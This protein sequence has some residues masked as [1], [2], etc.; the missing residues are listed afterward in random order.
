MKKDVIKIDESI[1]KNLYIISN[2]K[3]GTLTIIDGLCNTIIKEIEV[4]KRPYNLALKDNNTVAV[5]CDISNT[6]SFVNCING[7]IKQSCIPND[8]NLQIDRINKKIFISN[9]SEVIIYDIKLEKLLGRIS[10][11]LAVIDLK[12]NKDGSMLYILDTLM[13]E[14][15]IYSTDSYKL[16]YS[17]ANLG[18]NPNYFIIS[19]DDKIAYISIGSNIL[20]IDIYSKKIIEL[21]LPKESLISGMVL[22]DHTL[23]ASNLGLNRIELINIHTNI[24]YDFI[25]T[26]TP[27]PTRLFITDD[28][29][30]LLVT[31][32]NHESH[33]TM[34]IIDLNSNTLIG[35]ILMSKFNSQPYDVIS[36]SLP[37]T[38]VLP[39]AITD[40]QQGDQGITI[41]AKKIFAS[42]NENIDFPII[43]INLPKDTNSQKDINS[44]YIFENII[45]KPGII[46]GDSEIRSRLS[47]TSG[48]SSI[49]FIVRVN[50]IIEYIQN[51]KNNIM[52]GYF[53]KPI[54]IFFDIPK[55]HEINELELNIK[56]TTKLT[57]TPKILLNVI[58][59]GVTTRID[60][61]IIGED[62]IYLNN[63]EET[64]DN[65]EEH[66][67]AFTGSI[68]RIFP[69]GAAFPF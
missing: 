16:I 10:G 35:S 51:N 39:V 11:F 5:A 18:V 30:K 49:K 65:L 54:E 25:L 8:G 22:K 7:E 66:Y 32:R 62:E 4:G 37:Y 17:L 15:R 50:Y 46:V 57:D 64:S 24:A 61:K 60:I 56:T 6:I 63:T 59:F 27:E 29:T 26:S 45:F 9:T 47:T 28:N 67:E 38:Y 13:K 36:L 40:L 44:T 21:I 19:E 48:F 58:G 1:K 43:N 41:I 53:E 69:G 20:K 68:D 33:G 14:L 3:N 52:N 2:I 42:Y 31:N 55:G 34:D 23:Y 12:L